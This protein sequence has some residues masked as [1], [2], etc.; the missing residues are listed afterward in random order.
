MTRD[1][2]NM[3]LAS[4][5]PV[6]LVALKVSVMAERRLRTHYQRDPSDQQSLAAAYEWALGQVS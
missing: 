3:I 2:F 5:T 1:A 6:Q 4:M